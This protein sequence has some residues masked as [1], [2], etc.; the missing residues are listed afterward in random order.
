MSDVFNFPQVSSPPAPRPSYGS[1]LNSEEL[2]NSWI[3]TTQPQ[4]TAPPLSP[5]PL[6]PSRPRRVVSELRALM[7][8]KPNPAPLARVDSREQFMQTSFW[9]LDGSN[10]SLQG[11]YHAEAADASDALADKRPPAADFITNT[12]AQWYNSPT[13]MTRNRSSEL[14]KAAAQRGISLPDATSLTQQAILQ[15]HYPARSTG[16]AYPPPVPPLTLLPGTSYA[17]SNQN[18]RSDNNGGPD[19]DVAPAHHELQQSSPSNS[20]SRDTS[21]TMH[22]VS[23]PSA[24]RPSSV[25]SAVNQLRGTLKRK[26]GAKQ[27]GGGKAAVSLS[28][29]VQQE[30]LQPLALL[31][32]QASPQTQPVMKLTLTPSISAT[33]VP[34]VPESLAGLHL[35]LRR[36]DSAGANS[37]PSNTAEVSEGQ[38]PMGLLAPR[39]EES[40]GTLLDGMLELPQLNGPVVPPEQLPRTSS[41]P[42]LSLL[43]ATLSLQQPVLLHSNSVPAGH[44]SHALSGVDH[45]TR[46]G[47]LASGERLFSA[48]PSSNG[49]TS[50]MDNSTLERAASVNS[51]GSSDLV[52]GKGDVVMDATRRRREERQKK[53]AESKGRGG[54]APILSADVVALNKR[55]LDLEKE[56]RS[57]KLNLAFMNRKDSEQTTR[58]EELEAEVKR[59]RGRT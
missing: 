55:C 35:S 58:I 38:S 19:R 22:D 16:V 30:G 11:T 42:P 36:D 26:A 27:G 3:T 53:L 32:D 25:T 13:P 51:K 59:L 2:F 52:G 50:A 4:S 48:S 33:S 41:G 31:E 43:H 57:L 8:N 44:L 21:G 12:L 6:P 28:S 45:L 54:I 29:P 56:V 5:P 18:N 47:S 23:L 17:R 46:T 14:M 7:A 49:G 24:G 15:Q 9:L 37:R 1:R 40:V 10:A 34:P 39:A 20:G